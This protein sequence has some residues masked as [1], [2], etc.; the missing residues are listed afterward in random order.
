[1]N[2]NGNR[3][4]LQRAGIVLLLCFFLA[5]CGSGRGGSAVEEES[6]PCSTEQMLL[7]VASER[8]QTEELYTDRV[9]EVQT[10]AAGRRYEDA[11]YDE[12]KRFFVEMTAM[13][14]IA[15][16]RGVKLDAA[17]KKALT[18]AAETFYETSVRGQE[19]L[20][21]MTQEETEEIFRQYALAVKLRRT[22][23]EDRSAEVSESEAKVIRL[24]QIRTPDENTAMQIY[25]RASGGADLYA[26]AKAYDTERSTALKVARGDLAE[27]LEEAAFAL[28]DGEVSS[29]VLYD[30]QYYIFRSVDSYD[31]TETAMRRQSLQTKRLQDIVSEACAGYQKKHM[32]TMDPGKWEQVVKQAGFPYSGE[33][34]F[35]AVKE[36]LENEGI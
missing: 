20:R 29:P 23:L 11:F 1:M 24:Q 26:L 27:P 31:E 18:Q 35:S 32:V 25:D 34:F 4:G 21:A 14:G 10:G 36:A 33:N 5:A 28:E 16:E 8:R 15:A 3:R 22:M 30:G 12:M 2:M 17:E 9:W 7:L 13:N 6:V 19:P